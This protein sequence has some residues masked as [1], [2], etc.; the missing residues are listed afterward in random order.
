MVDHILSHEKRPDC[1]ARSYCGHMT[2]VQPVS[3]VVLRFY[4]VFAA[5]VYLELE[6][7]NTFE[8][9]CDCFDILLLLTNV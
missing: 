3:A 7:H 8:Y 9:S 6:M 4:V 1:M 2:T 5:M